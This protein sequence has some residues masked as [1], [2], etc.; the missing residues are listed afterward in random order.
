MIFVSDVS[1][2][3]PEV[4]CG[5]AAPTCVDAESPREIRFGFTCDRMRIDCRAA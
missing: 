2:V 4:A 3:S 5:E 1:S